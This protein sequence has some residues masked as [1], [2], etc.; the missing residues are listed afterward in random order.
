MEVTREVVLE[1]PVEEVWSAL[2]E[3]ERLEEW[4]AN[5]VELDLEPGGEGTF[6]WDDGEERHAVVEEVEPERRFAFTWDE[7]HVA[8]ELDEVEAARA[9]SSP[10]RSAPAGGRALSL[11][12]AFALASTRDRRLRGSRRPDPAAPARGARRARG[13]GDRARG[14]AAG[15]AAGGLEAPRRRCARPASSTSRRA[16]RETLYRLNAAPLDERGRVDRARRRRVGRPAR[17]VARAPRTIAPWLRPSSARSRWR[18]F[19]PSR[20]PPPSR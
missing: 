5:D 19:T 20:T 3:P 10:R 6:R 7:S 16:G 9:W 11:Q 15:D 18:R 8:I 2:T 13:V 4:F 14:R 17:A 12:A 1:A